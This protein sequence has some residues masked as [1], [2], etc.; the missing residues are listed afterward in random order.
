MVT[1][2]KSGFSLSPCVCLI[3]E[4][5]VLCASTTIAEVKMLHYNV[6]FESVFKNRFPGHLTY[7]LHVLTLLYTGGESTRLL[8]SFNLPLLV[9]RNDKI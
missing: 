5:G 6:Y 2:G 1:V 4:E 3:V 9:D 7:I 8:R